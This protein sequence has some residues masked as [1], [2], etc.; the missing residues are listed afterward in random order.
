MVSRFRTLLCLPVPSCLSRTGRRRIFFLGSQLF[1]H[2]S[3]EFGRVDAGSNFEVRV[4]GASNP[5]QALPCPGWGAGALRQ[6]HHICTKCALAPRQFSQGV[7]LQLTA[8]P[9]FLVICPL[10]LQ[11]PLLPQCEAALAAF[12]DKRISSVFRPGLLSNAVGCMLL[13]VDTFSM[14]FFFFS[15]SSSSHPPS[16]ARCRRLLF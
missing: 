9:F 1:V 8:R 13:H 14:A 16:S 3:V 11:L 12:H 5:S 6:E 15:L 4:G 2:P 7:G 10:H